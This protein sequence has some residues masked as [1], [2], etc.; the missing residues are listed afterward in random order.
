[1]GRGGR[2][3]I[4]ER[5]EKEDE[6]AEDRRDRMLGEGPQSAVDGEDEAGRLPTRRHPTPS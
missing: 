2:T 6:P 4:G 5:Q 3:A 1:V